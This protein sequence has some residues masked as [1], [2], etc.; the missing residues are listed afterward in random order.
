MSETDPYR[1][2]V[3]PT[4]RIALF[5]YA[6]KDIA[7]EQRMVGM[8]IGNGGNGHTTDKV[9]VSEDIVIRG[10]RHNSHTVGRVKRIYK[11]WPAVGTSYAAV[12]IYIRPYILVTIV[13]A[14]NVCRRHHF[15]QPGIATLLKSLYGGTYAVRFTGIGRM[16]CVGTVE[17]VLERGALHH[18][19]SYLGSLGKGSVLKVKISTAGGRSHRY[20]CTG[21]EPQTR[22][23]CHHVC[24]ALISAVATSANHKRHRGYC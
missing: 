15:S 10:I 2:A 7:V 16:H 18:E 24:I 4:E 17:I 5:R 23:L 3:G 19:Q 6:H 11:V 13:L 21:R 1:L 22:D 9:V 14:V 12:G 20:A 8:L